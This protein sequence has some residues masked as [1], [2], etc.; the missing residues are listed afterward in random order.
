[1]FQY[2]GMAQGDRVTGRTVYFDPKP[3]DKILTK[4]YNS[5][6]GRRFRD[7]NRFSRFDP[8]DGWTKRCSQCL[9]IPFQ[10]ADTGPFGIVESGHGPA[11]MFQPGIVDLPIVDSTQ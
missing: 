6:S 9:K 2:L 4:V 10:V 1:M 11:W 8:T 3:A 5:F 7:R